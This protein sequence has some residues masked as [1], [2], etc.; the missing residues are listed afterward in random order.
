MSLATIAVSCSSEELVDDSG[1]ALREGEQLVNIRL[2][3]L[4]SAAVPAGRAGDDPAGDLGGSS[5]PTTPGSAA[6]NTIEELTIYSFVGIDTTGAVYAAEAESGRYRFEST[7]ERMY[8]YK[9]GAADNDMLLTADGNGY[10]VAIP[11]QKDIYFRSFY[12]KA[13]AGNAP[14]SFVA[15]PVFQSD[16]TTLN[17]RTGASVNSCTNS[18]SH[19]H[20]TLGDDKLALLT[21]NP[22]DAVRPPLPA[23]G[24]A[25]WQEE[26]T[27]AYFEEHDMFATA[28]LAKG[29]TVNLSRR[30]AR[31]DINN[32]AT[33]GFTVTGISAANVDYTQCLLFGGSISGGGRSSLTLNRLPLTNATSIPAALYIPYGNYGS[34]YQLDIVIHGIFHGINTELHA[35]TGYVNAN[36]RYII[37]IIN[38]GS[39]VAA[40]I[41]LADWTDTEDNLDSDDLFGTLNSGTNFSVESGL[42]DYIEQ[43]GNDITV[44][45]SNVYNFT[46]LDAYKAF[47]IIGT[48]GN[49]KPVGIVIPEGVTW[50]AVDKN[51]EVTTGTYSVS[52]NVV[53][54]EITTPDEYYYDG[55]DKRDKTVLHGAPPETVTLTLVTQETVDGKNVQRNHEYRVTRDWFL[56]NDMALEYKLTESSFVLPRGA[57]INASTRTITL[58]PFQVG[59]FYNGD[60]S[61]FP[62]QYGGFLLEDQSWLHP[63]REQDTDGNIN[64]LFAIDDNFQSSSSRSATL[65]VRKWDASAGKVITEDYTVTQTAGN[66]DPALLTTA[67]SIGGIDPYDASG[68]PN[69]PYVQYGNITIPAGHRQD[70]PQTGSV[71]FLASADEK[72]FI[73]TVTAGAD[74]LRLEGRPYEAAFQYLSAYDGKYL[75]GI[76]I[77]SNV[78]GEERTG[79]IKILY[80]NSSDGSITSKTIS[81]T[82][83]AG[84]G[85]L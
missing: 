67:V 20:S 49:T 27:G 18:N 3:G 69:L 70:Y 55:I 2:G 84:A 31:F 85:T 42:T 62:F 56:P 43:N 77:L 19:S 68:N 83:A 82:Q 65:T 58:P 52:L 22:A 76:R 40:N 71:V 12:A 54:G 28:D 6:E 50:L 72:G 24:T 14:A 30:V 26:L 15:V 81:V 41:S 34:S 37:N 48:T 66:F 7:L 64:I 29:L 5:T 4:G 8:H 16:G 17:N 44:L 78:G 35:K 33:T 73:A 1:I 13:N 75:R 21:N 25:I 10:S 51:T 11:V 57:T 60:G 32:P 79:T 45:Y 46:K 38:T 63:N 80:R 61:N 36:T 53:P 39:T 74:W 47:T 9:A 59:A 23:S